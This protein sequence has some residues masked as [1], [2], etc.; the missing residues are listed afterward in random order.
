MHIDNYININ[1]DKLLLNGKYWRE[2]IEDDEISYVVNTTLIAA[3]INFLS[4]TIHNYFDKALIA[5]AMKVLPCETVLEHLNNMDSN[6]GVEVYHEKE[7]DMA[8]KCGSNPIVVNGYYKS[9]SFLYKS[10]INNVFIINIDSITELQKVNYFAK[11]TN[12]HVNV[13]IRIKHSSRSKMGVDFQELNEIINDIS[14]YN[15]ISIISV[16]MHPGT[17]SDL[18]ENLYKY[19]RLEHAAS[20]LEKSGIEISYINLGGGIGELCECNQN[21][22]W[23]FSELRTLFKKYKKCQFI[24]EP[25]RALVADAGIIFSKVSSINDYDNTINI[26]IAVMPFLFTTSATLKVNF[27]DKITRCGCSSYSISGI[28][29]VS[30]DIISSDKIKNI[31]P[32]DIKEGDVFAIYN[33]G[34]YVFDR[35]GEYAFED[36]RTI[37]I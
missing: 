14:N 36:I 3:N 34:A 17:K 22:E 26:N 25:G 15:N 10:V 21:L 1:S 32:D 29:P 5:F 27:P 2:L 28:W 12:R 33:A 37:F 20:M 35:L 30:D 13:G 7:L 8:I 6:V 18:K 24:F 16:H 23:Y 31:I 4:E 19:R 11:E 9:D